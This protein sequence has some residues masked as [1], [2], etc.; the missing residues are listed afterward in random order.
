[1]FCSRD[2]IARTLSHLFTVSVFLNFSNKGLVRLFVMDL[3]DVAE[4]YA[5]GVC[6][7]LVSYIVGTGE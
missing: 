4:N 1:M 6:L 5:N 3:Q 7:L 2:I